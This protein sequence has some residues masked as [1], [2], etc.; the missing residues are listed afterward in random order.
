MGA[1]SSDI[2]ELNV[3]SKRESQ[4]RRKFMGLLEMIMS[5]LLRKMKLKKGQIFALWLLREKKN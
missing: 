5:A 3:L 4:K 1:R 2:I